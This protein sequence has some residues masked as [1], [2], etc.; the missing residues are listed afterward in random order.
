MEPRFLLYT[1]RI[2]IHRY[3]NLDFGLIRKV[4]FMQETDQ[5]DQTHKM[6]T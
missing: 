3:T 2:N 6:E 5:P 1:V 4:I